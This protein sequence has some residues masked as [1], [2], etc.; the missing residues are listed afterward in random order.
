MPTNPKHLDPTSRSSLSQL[1][2]FQRPA[3][4]P[5][6]APA[7]PAPTAV[8]GQGD[9]RTP[10]H[11]KPA[12]HPLPDRSALSPQLPAL[13]TAA[14]LQAFCGSAG[15]SVPAKRP[16][17]T[18][19]RPG[20]SLGAAEPER[21]AGQPR[22]AAGGRTRHSSGAELPE[23][24]PGRGGRAPGL[25]VPRQE[26][27]RSQHQ[28]APKKRSS[29]LLKG[30]STGAFPSALSPAVRSA[31]ARARFRASP[32]PRAPHGRPSPGAGGGS[33]GCGRCAAPGAAFGPGHTLR[34]ARAEPPAHQPPAGPEL[35]VPFSMDLTTWP[36]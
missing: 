1:W 5:C 28:P 20:P 33:G 22:G 31:T 14:P 29:R 23:S 18:E 17:G 3:G 7:P 30:D 2:H 4:H 8:R 19:S 36:P 35:P 16:P 6:P 24:E 15:A 13:I 32:A 26:P 11:T 9:T 27:A 21:A 10:A 34:A 25:A 12:P